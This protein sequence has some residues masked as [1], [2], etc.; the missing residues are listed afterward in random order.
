MHTKIKYNTDTLLLIQ[1]YGINNFSPK[2]CGRQTNTEYK[3]ILQT[4]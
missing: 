2:D 3:T 4:I 1:F